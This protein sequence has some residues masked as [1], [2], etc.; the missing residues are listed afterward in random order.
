MFVISHQ[1]IL[2]LRDQN[3]ETTVIVRTRN[4]AVQVLKVLNLPT[5]ENLINIGVFLPTFEKMFA[6]VYFVMSL[7]TSNSPK[8]PE[9]HKIKKL[10]VN[11]GSNL[12]YPNA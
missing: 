10:N 11:L 3:S 5:V 7:V 2:Q 8:A 4:E 9:N 6:F 12:Y 1:Q